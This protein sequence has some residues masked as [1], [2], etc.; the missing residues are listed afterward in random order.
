MLRSLVD[1]SV[2]VEKSGVGEAVGE[3]DGVAVGVAWWEPWS[4]RQ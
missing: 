4:R 3:R 2:L 1:G